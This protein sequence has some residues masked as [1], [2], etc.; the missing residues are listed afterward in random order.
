MI[1]E[2]EIEEVET[3]GYLS[4]L[5]MNESNPNARR[6]I[7]SLLLVSV[8]SFVPCEYSHRG[9]AVESLEK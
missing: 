8:T 5:R 3:A 6:R 7:I 4:L 2:V 1:F 9:L